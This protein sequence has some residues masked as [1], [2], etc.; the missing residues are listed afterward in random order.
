MFKILSTAY[1]T[2]WHCTGMGWARDE[3]TCVHTPWGLGKKQEPFLS[4][5]C[6]CVFRAQECR[7]GVPRE[8]QQGTVSLSLCSEMYLSSEPS[9]KPWETLTLS[10]CC[11]CR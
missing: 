8:K 4:A 5:M 1:V 3:R 9:S 2:L 10:P 7:A 6:V 11:I